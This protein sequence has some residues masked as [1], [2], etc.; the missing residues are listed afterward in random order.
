MTTRARIAGLGK[1]L[2]ERILTNAD[3]ERMV[4]TS[5][6]WIIERTGVRERRLA[7]ENETSSTLGIEAARQALAQAEIDAGDLDLIIVATTTPDGMFPATASLVQDGLGARR[8]GAF[9][10]NA[11]CVGFVSAVATASQFIQSGAY[12]RVLVVGSDVLSRLVDWKDRGTCVLFGDGAGAVV[13]EASDRGGPLSFVFHSDGGAASA[14]YAPGPCSTPL[15]AEAGFFIAMDG[16]QVFKFAVHA[17]E[18][19]TREVMGSLSLGVNDI[20]LLIPHQANMR[21]IN[22][23]AKALGLRPERAMVNVD[24]YGNTSSASIPMALQEASEQGRLH[25][26]DRIVLVAFGGGLVWGAL[27]LEWAPVGPLRTAAQTAHASTS[28]S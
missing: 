13:L 6:S 14:L 11:A 19:A 20:D 4:D 3:L 21:I 23:T 9:D 10:I 25:D 5:D 27:A 7:S 1:Y 15:A 12:Q 18:S 28:G 2:P 16:P 22:A 8:A 17:M 24:R 26:G